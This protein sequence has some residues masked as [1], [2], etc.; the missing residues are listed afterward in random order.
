MAATIGAK[1][2]TEPMLTEHQYEREIRPYLI[3]GSKDYAQL[4]AAEMAGFALMVKMLGP[5]ISVM[6]RI[7]RV[8]VDE[9]TVYDG[10][11]EKR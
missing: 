4:T 2:S 1:W 5:R 10:H 6:H 11:A 9:E 3:D 7:E 8:D